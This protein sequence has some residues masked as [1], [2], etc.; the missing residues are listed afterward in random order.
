MKASGIRKTADKIFSLRWLIGAVLL[1][2]L[3]AGAFHGDSMACYDRYIE[4]GEGGPGLYPILGTER[5]VRVDEWAINNP[6][7]ISAIY[8]EHPFGSYNELERGG[9]T[10]NDV[11]GIH[12]GP[13]TAGYNIFQYVYLILDPERA[14]SFCWYAPLILAFLLAV[15][16]CLI[17]TEGKRFYSLCGACLIVFSPFWQWWEVSGKILLPMIACLVCFYHLL[18]KDKLWQKLLLALGLGLA[19]AHFVTALYPAWQVPFGY[20]A[21]GIALWMILENR[22]RMLAQDKKRLYL[23]GDKVSL[24]LLL[25]AMLLAGLLI[26]GH[27]WG[28]RDYIKAVSETIYPGK[29]REY[30]GEGLGKILYYFV[31]PL[32]PYYDYSQNVALSNESEIAGFFS[33]FPIPLI[34]SL[35]CLLRSRKKKEKCDFFLLP[36]LLFSVLFLFYLTTGLPAFLADLTMLSNSISY[37]VV[38]ALGFIQILLII[39]LLGYRREAERENAGKEDGEKARAAI[40]PLKE[41]AGCAAAFLAALVSAAAAW[42]YCRQDMADYIGT[43]KGILLVLVYALT[44]AAVLLYAKKPARIFCGVSLLILSLISGFTV[45]PLVQGFDALWSKPSAQRIREIVKSEP[46]SLWL[47]TNDIHCGY[48]LANGARVKNSNN[49]YPDME[50]FKQLDEN[51]TYEEVYNRYCHISVELTEEK[52]SFVL[53]SADTILLRLNYADLL[54]SGIDY[55]FTEDVCEDTGEVSFDCVYQNGDLKIYHV[56]AGAQG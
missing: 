55:I 13:F 23:V 50:W 33:F 19:F 2:I 51:G 20:I 12:I 22:R 28:I 5:M 31:S 21:L 56:T 1:I 3:T 27:L 54:Q 16:L 35:I 40:T 29:R 45:R 42:L 26:A 18:R 15:E 14:F 41:Y 32:L 52:S 47:C 43:K 46:Q 4:S 30:G 7:R 44:A 39:R 8:G 10:L 11:A 17:L 6:A 49:F 53:C 25:G 34:A 38:D 9:H 36:Q 37:R 24:F 48:V